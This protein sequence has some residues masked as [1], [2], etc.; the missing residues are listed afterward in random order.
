MCLD[1]DREIIARE[2]QTKPGERRDVGKLG[3]CHL[4]LGFDGT[5]EGRDDHARQRVSLRPGDA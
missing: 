3:V 1:T 4:H 2:A 5:A